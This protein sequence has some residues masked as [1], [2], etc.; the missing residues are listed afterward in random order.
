MS[1]AP[2]PAPLP[3][4]PQSQLSV[5][6]ARKQKIGIAAGAEDAKYHIKYKELKR[7]VKDIETENDKL[8]F[9]VLQT[10]LN[11]RRMKMERAVL[12]ERLSEVPPSPTRQDRLPLPP[13]HPLPGGP[14]HQ[15]SSRPGPGGH[16][17]RDIRDHPSAM[18]PD[19]LHPSQEYIRSHG[20]PRGPPPLDTRSVSTMDGGPGSAAAVSPHMSVHAPRRMS[21]GHDTGRHH[22][23]VGQM[24]PVHPSHYENSRGHSHSNSHTSPPSHHPHP[25]SSH[26]RE[27]SHSSSHSRHV[28]PQSYRGGAGQQHLY[29][30][31]LPPVHHTMHS[32]PLSE[33]E[34]PRRGEPV[35]YP[36]PHADPHPYDLHSTRMPLSPRAHPSDARS[37]GRIHSH[38]RLGPGTYIS[39]EEFHDKQQLRDHDRV[40]DWE[41]EHRER[42]RN[43]DYHTSN[44]RSRDLGSSQMHS[45]PLSVQRSRSSQLDRGD[46]DPHVPPPPRS[47]DEPAY[48]HHDVHSGSGYPPHL[49]RSE[50]PGSGSGS[51][52]AGAG[53]TEVPSRPD[54][55]NQYYNDRDRARPSFRLRPVAQTNDDMDF[56]HEDGRSSQNRNA[57][58][59]RNA[60]PSGGAGPGGS[61]SGGNYPLPDQS[62][63]GL[64]SRKRNRND[65]DVDSDNDVGD[66]PSTAVNTLYSAAR[67]QD[68][69]SSK[70]Y[71]REH[72]SRRSVDNHEDARMGPP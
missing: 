18:D 43:R 15:H 28:A 49:S 64:E 11:I 29:P 37:S 46:Y 22:M 1:P 68:D 9:K 23:P 56:H 45:P 25:S 42:D 2:S 27:R 59:D 20:N 17:Y 41:R 52:S 35:D 12:Y 13:S 70:R 44:S 36:G 60:G 24:P 33:R 10:K 16:Q 40:T 55:R 53:I 38:Q 30:D 66:G 8:H 63:P 67:L 62:R 54:S 47:R 3:P 58:A 69:R 5:P 71:H 19:Q 4:P 39:R 21:V 32:P 61:G 31:S 65:M 34:R 51:G 57:A 14:L 26:T 72:Q 7:K 6:T 50:T 48:Y